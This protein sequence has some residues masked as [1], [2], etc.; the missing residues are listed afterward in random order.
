MNIKKILFI[1]RDNIGDL[2]CTTP[3]IRAVRRKYPDAKIGILVHTYNADIIRNNPDIN[4]I[5]VYQK[6]KHIP[7]KHKFSVWLDNLKVI[8]K[9]RKEKYDAAVGCGSYSPGVAKYTFL[10]GAKI[11]IGHYKKDARNFFYSRPVVEPLK[12]AHEVL[13]TFNLLSP[14][15]ITGQ[16][17][18]LILIPDGSE[19]KKIEAVKNH[20]DNDAKKPFLAVVISARIKKNKWTIEKFI[21]LIK[22]LL[23]QN[24]AHILLLW[25]PGSK[26]S[27]TFP[28]DDKS[29]HQIIGFFDNDILPYPTPTLRSLIA[30]IS[31]SDI[32]LTLDTGSLH[33]SAAV[34]KPTIA[35][36]TNAKASRWYPWKT[37]SIVI[38]A[39]QC[40]EDIIVDD[41]LRAVDIFIKDF[42]RDKELISTG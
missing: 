27:A 1:R 3:A 8:K 24:A 17:G 14:L 22:S 37:K 40:V 38:T 4:E 11:R 5:Y 34:K 32:V 6:A 13:R 41:V 26:N 16:P 19:I 42:H 7:E 2:I 21:S 31:L 18:E 10:S 9:I 39:E 12:D 36:M 28:G 23:M 20:F 15:G 25:A 33:M 35:L 30:A 29:A